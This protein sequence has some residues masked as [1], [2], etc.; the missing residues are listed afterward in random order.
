MKAE[1]GKVLDNEL[2][3]I[4]SDEYDLDFEITE[5][6]NTESSS[7]EGYNYNNLRNKPQI[8]SV[9]LEDNLSLKDLGLRAIYYHTIEEWNSQPQLISE[10][11]AIY[12][13]SNYETITE[14]EIVK[15]VPGIKIGDGL[16]Q[17]AKLPFITSKVISMIED[18]P[19]QLNITFDIDS[20]GELIMTWAK[21]ET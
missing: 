9:T 10:E 21:E 17:V 18:I 20:S 19:N 11:G 14:G 5:T 7:I 6:I 16:T 1:Y 8:N 12:I 3:K 4:D 15:A 13:Y 2:I